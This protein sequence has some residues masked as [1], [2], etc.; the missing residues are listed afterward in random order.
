VRLVHDHEIPVDLAQP[1]KYVSAFR[2]VERRDHPVALQPLI[3]A[4]LLAKIL[5]LHDE[6]LGVELLLQLALPLKGEVRRAD[7]QDALGKTVQFQL[8]NQQARH[9]GFARA[10]VVGKQEA[11]ARELEQMLIH[12]LELMR[13]R[14]HA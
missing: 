13:Q 10:G 3:H 14:V 11:N 8:A 1:R 4:E 6:E 9:D 5:P 7:D 2:Q 12:R